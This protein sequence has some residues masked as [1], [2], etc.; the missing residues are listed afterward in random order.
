[1]SLTQ[2]PVSALRQPPPHAQ[3]NTRIADRLSRFADLLERQG[4]DRFRIRA[5]RAAIAEISTMDRPLSVIYAEAGTEGL[6]AL[7]GIGPGI[8]TA[9]AEMLRTGR[10]AQ[11]DRLEVALTP[12]KLFASIP[13]IGVILAGRLVELLGAQTLEDLEAALRLGD[14]EVPGLG[15]RRRAAILAALG[16]RLARVP[17]PRAATAR[18]SLPEPPVS[19]LLEADA[20]YRQKA[21]AGE[22]RQIA[23]RR[24]NPTGAAWLPILHVRRDQ[25]HLTL[26]Y[27]NTARAHELGRTRDWV[28][29]H[30]HSDG[31]PEAQSTV[32]TETQGPLQGRR[33]VRGRE[34]ECLAFYGAPS[35]PGAAAEGGGQWAL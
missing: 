4:A 23:P 10:W 29:V 27:S 26:L 11:L 2:R 3:P 34:G 20:L 30:F 31:E 16:A 25:W 8:A 6:M 19:L 18:L 12:Q 7:K 15:S 35:A 14:A 1:M 32:V 13:G 9:I 24:F 21:A 17:R 5:Y 22:L 28:V 33:V